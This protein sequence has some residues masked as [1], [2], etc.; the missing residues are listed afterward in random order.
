M[1]AIIKNGIAERLQNG[2]YPFAENVFQPARTLIAEQKAQFGVVDLVD[3]P[4]IYNRLTQTINDAGE[5]LVGGVWK[6]KWDVV[7]RDGAAI[8]QDLTNAVQ[9]HLDSEAR[10]RGY[11]NIVS[12]CSY[13]GA[14]NPFQSEG[15]AFV[16]WRGNVWA[17]C[18]AVMSEVTAGTRAIPS[19]AELIGLLP[20]F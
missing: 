12:A 8:I 14:A 11:D 17:A 1:Y 7:A 13:A 2:N 16:A 10:A 20:A 6:R 19:E 5:E 9:N 18:H 15:T 4:P 3:E